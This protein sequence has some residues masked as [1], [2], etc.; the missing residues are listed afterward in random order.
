L[1]SLIEI[2]VGRLLETG[3]NKRVFPDQGPAFP[4]ASLERL[5]QTRHRGA[6]L[7]DQPRNVGGPEFIAKPAQERIAAVDAKTAYSTPGGPWENGFI[8]KPR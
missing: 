8:E 6:Q 7:R 4:S 3:A 1:K 2:G 5:M